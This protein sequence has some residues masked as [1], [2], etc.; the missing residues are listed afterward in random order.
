[1]PP[2]QA[3]GQHFTTFYIATMLYFMADLIYVGVV[4]R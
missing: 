1:M 4:P 2:V 3:T